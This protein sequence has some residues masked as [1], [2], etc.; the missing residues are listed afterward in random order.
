MM[1]QLGRRLDE[2]WAKG[3][4]VGTERGK[5]RVGEPTRERHSRSSIL[6]TAIQCHTTHGHL[7][8]NR[9]GC[10]L[11]VELLLVLIQHYRLESSLGSWLGRCQ[12]A[13]LLIKL[14][15]AERC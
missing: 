3:H 13:K 6:A 7:A 5:A 8:I 10:S 15:L 1:V 11:V 2:V 14:R 9:K 4:V 12:T